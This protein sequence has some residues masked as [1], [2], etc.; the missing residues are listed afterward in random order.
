MTMNEREKQALHICDDIEK[1][2]LQLKQ[3]EKTVK[4]MGDEFVVCVRLVEKNN[5]VSS[6]I[7]GNGLKTKSDETK[8]DIPSLDLFSVRLYLF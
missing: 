4:M 3:K 7:K 5:D 1:L 8:E 2:K 6:V